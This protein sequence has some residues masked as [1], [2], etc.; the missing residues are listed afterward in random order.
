MR[1]TMIKE[2][3]VQLPVQ[4]VT[5][6]LIRD[7]SER[8]RRSSGRKPCSGSMSTTATRMSR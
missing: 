2:M 6:E 8:V 3:H 4:E 7:L 5:Q 1:D